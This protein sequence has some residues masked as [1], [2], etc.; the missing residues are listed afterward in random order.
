MAFKTLHSHGVCHGDIR[1][2]N[3]LIRKDEGVKLLILRGVCL[4]VDKMMLLEKEDEVRL[5]SSQIY[6]C[7]IDLAS[8]QISK[9]GRSQRRSLCLW[10]SK[11]CPF[12]TF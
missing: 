1:I 2:V 8:L 6:L 10:R 11:Y 3:V 12:G 7:P 9:R 4:N 5:V